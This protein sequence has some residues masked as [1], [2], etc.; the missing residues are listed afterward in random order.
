MLIE[1]LTH[2]QHILH[3]RTFNRA[4]NALTDPSSFVLAENLIPTLSSLQQKSSRNINA[5]CE[6]LLR[7]AIDDPGIPNPKKAVTNLGQKLSDID[8]TEHTFSEILRLYVRERNGF[9]DQVKLN[10]VHVDLRNDR[11]LPI[12]DTNAVRRVV[13]IVVRR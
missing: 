10:S 8:I 7:L 13:P 11:C 5:L 2:F 3:I 1:F 12:D 9:D 6:L 4:V